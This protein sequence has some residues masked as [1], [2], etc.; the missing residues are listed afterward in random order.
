M[1]FEEH[2]LGS[3][4][5]ATG[6]RTRVLVV[7]DHPTFRYGVIELINRMG[8]GVEVCG[9][10]GDGP[11]A[12]EAFRTLQPDLVVMDISLPGRDGIEITKMMRA[13]SPRAAVLIL[14]MHDEALYGL[15]ALRAGAR[16]Y[17]RKDDA[18]THLADAMRHAVRN[19]YYLSPK[20]KTHLIQRVMSQ[21][22]RFNEDS[23]VQG[24]SDRE[25]EVFQWLGKGLG[26]RQIAERLGL[27]VKTIETHRAHIKTKLCV[28]SSDNMVKL[29]RDWL[30]MGEG[31]PPLEA[32]GGRN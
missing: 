6:V 7:D 20:L 31:V 32:A 14:S 4:L 25:M 13:E 2:P 5:A 9:E 1:N 27:S 29:A 12:L 15:R 11:S 30:A 23:A 19:D 16:G 22:E 18:L 17:L 3:S 26:T 24:L 28:E 10:A 21:D 8:S